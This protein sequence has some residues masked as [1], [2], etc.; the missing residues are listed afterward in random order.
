[1]LL[2]EN[3]MTVLAET[4]LPGGVRVYKGF[5]SRHVGCN[6]LLK[7]T[8]I[9]FVTQSLRHAKAYSRGST[10]PY[11][12]KRQVR[13]FNLTQTNIKLLFEMNY[14]LSRETRLGLQFVMGTNL[15]RQ[16]QANAYAK[17]VGTP[18]SLFKSRLDRPGERL[19]VADIDHEVFQNFSRDFLIP[20]KYDGF[21]SPPKFSGFH[22]GVFPS[23]IM[24]CDAAKVL[25]RKATETQKPVNVLSQQSLIKLLPE[26]FVDYSRRR[27]TLIRPYGG[28]VMYLGGGMAVKLYLAARRVKVPVKVVD[29][30][31]FDFTFAVHKP[32]SQSGVAARVFAMRK[33]IS[34]HVAG[35]VAW[36]NREYKTT[37]AQVVVS[38]MIPTF[39]VFP[40]TGKRVYQVISFKLQFPGV[41]K[42]VDFVDATLAYVPGIDRRFIHLEY[43]R[44]YGIPIERLRHQYRNVL[45]VLAGSFVLKDPALRSRNPLTGNRP[46]KGLKNTARLLAL[47][48][49][50]ALKPRQRGTGM[51]R[52]FLKRIKA[53]NVEGARRRARQI[54]KNIQKN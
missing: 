47:V 43:S 38:S 46:E 3:K 37:N 28:F 12:T 31:D 42:A 29:T 15:T 51:V 48:K 14:P 19:S 13:L 26:L 45:S 53:R 33:I 35:F 23:E 10:C 39:K 5:R 1:M 44:L 22:G 34:G 9:F 50:R 27:R 41:K 20:E 17:L 25:V 4:V 21:Y 36:L 8:R 54:I 40:P 32:L 30:K 18:G 7:D 24:L 2:S 6:T 49:A 52:D 11:T 16:Q